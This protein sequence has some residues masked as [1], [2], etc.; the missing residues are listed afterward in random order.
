M[1][2]ENLIDCKNYK[3]IDKSVSTFKNLNTEDDKGT[4]TINDCK[5]CYNFDLSKGVLSDGIGINEPLFKYNLQMYRMFKNINFESIYHIEACWYFPCWDST[6]NEFTPIIVTYCSNEKFY[7]NLLHYP[8]K[9][10]TE[11]VGFT[12]KEVPLVINCKVNDLDTM[13]FVSKSGGM[14]T[15]N[16]VEGLKTIDNAPNITSMCIGYDRM[17]A[18]VDGEKRSVLYSENLK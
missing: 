1:F 13:V 15:W 7:Y 8:G 6:H 11:I 12:C 9:D 14:F 17:F 5:M 10:M 3:N 2:Y 4:L 16:I 18:T